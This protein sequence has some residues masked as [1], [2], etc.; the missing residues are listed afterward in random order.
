MQAAA[1]RIDTDAFAALVELLRGRRVAALAGAGCSTESGIPDYRGPDSATRRRPPIQYL[2][3]TRHEAARARY[4][5]RSAVGWPRV[6]Q[7][8]PNP[9]HLALAQLEQARLLAGVITQNVDGL[10]GKAG[11]RRVVELHGSLSR[12]CCLACG[13]R[14]PRERY[15]AELL[16]ANP[17]WAR[18]LQAVRS[19]G[20]APAPDGDAGVPDDLLHGFRVPP[21]A[22]CGGLC[23]PD[24]VFFGENVPPA[25]VEAACDVFESA[26]VL[27]V[28]GSS[29]TVFSGRRFVYK[30]R[31]ARLPVAIV[32]IG[33]TR[34]D[35]LASVKVDGR[36]GDLLPRL[37]QAL[38]IRHP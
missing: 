4:W 38:S 33:P 5:A 32:N 9:A 31:D 1:T 30:A 11:S 10:H 24:V 28:V 18:H 35:D 27:L 20:V 37:A 6:A 19:S 15:Q 2:E 17:A 34:C 22:S 25:R 26:D 7:A 12:V 23:K 16:A 29:L 8:V 21:C 36:L 14:F 3:F 13:A